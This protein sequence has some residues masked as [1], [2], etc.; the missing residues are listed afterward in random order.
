VDPARLELPLR[1]S[2]VSDKSTLSSPILGGLAQIGRYFQIISVVPAVLVVFSVY[3]LVAAGAPSR[4]PSWSALVEGVHSLGFQGVTVIVLAV[5]IVGMMIHP[6]QFAAIQF[7]EGY[8]GPGPLAR[9]ASLTRARIHLVRKNRYLGQRE[10]AAAKLAEALRVLEKP[11]GRAKIRGLRIEALQAHL[12]STAFN[13]AVRRY[14][15]EPHRVMPTRLGNMLRSYEDA[16]GKPFGR[17]AAEV[18]THLMYLAP[19]EHTEYV[20]DARTDL[21]LAVRFVISWVLV[22]ITS[23]LLVWPYGLWITVPIGAYLLAWVSYRGY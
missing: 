6:F 10:V 17:Q 12:G 11:P 15:V 21:D 13:T 19:S 14:P 18:T 8:W 2:S 20:D 22:A 3:G 4:E 5:L 16:A 23:F 7:L 1:D 9:T